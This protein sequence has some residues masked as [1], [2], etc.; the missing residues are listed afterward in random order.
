[1]EDLLRL[2]ARG[3]VDEVIKGWAERRGDAA[4]E[5][6]LRR[7]FELLPPD[8]KEALLAASLYNG[9]VTV[10]ELR[11]ITGF[12][13]ARLE[14]AIADLQRF[15]LMPKP[16]LIEGVDRFE[17]NPNIRTLVRRALGTTDV[18][19]RV[20]NAAKAVR[21]ELLVRAEERLKI[22]AYARQAVA[23]TRQG[24]CADAESTLPL[25]DLVEQVV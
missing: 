11:Q 5:Y 16:R 19:R 24:N 7:E 20:E 23:L 21:G 14:N 15:Y 10:A 3:G 12:T 13:S 2:S 8:A 25:F 1:M 17:M 6:A 22:S 4:R 9:P 18:Y